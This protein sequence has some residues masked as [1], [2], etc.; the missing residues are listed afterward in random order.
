[1]SKKCLITPLIN[2]SI[3][4]KNKFRM[5]HWAECKNKRKNNI[6]LV[7]I[8]NDKSISFV[9]TKITFSARRVIPRASKK[10]FSL[11]KSCA[12]TQTSNFQPHNI[13]WPDLKPE[14][15]VPSTGKS[16][17]FE[18][19]LRKCWPGKKLVQKILKFLES[20][21]NSM[22]QWIKIRMTKIKF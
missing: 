10:L 4:E 18:C 16:L 12:N 13:S 3:K 2:P 8:V 21:V 20:S 5:S 17:R 7:Q 11:I 15:R 14:L 1:M 22:V 19:A 6:S 9:W